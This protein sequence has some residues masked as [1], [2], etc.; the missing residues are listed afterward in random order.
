MEHILIKFVL[1]HLIVLDDGTLFK[2]AFIAICQALSINYDILA[3]P[4]H[5]GL[6][7]EHFHRFLNKCVTIAPKERGTNDIFVTTSIAAVYAWNSIPIDGTD[8]LRSI[9]A[10]GRKVHFPIDFNFNDL[11]KL[12]QNYAQGALEYLKL[13]ESSR[14]FTKFILNFFIKDH[15]TAH[16][17]R[18]NISRNLVTLKPGDIVM[19]RTAI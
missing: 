19:P 6:T 13:T 9:S 10:I 4:N 17:E 5:K 7:V 16:T 11:P 8:I 15:R 14:H 2:G 1:C 3:K 12:T 18:I